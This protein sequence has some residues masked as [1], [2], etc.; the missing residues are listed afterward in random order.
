M[1]GVYNRMKRRILYKLDTIRWQFFGYNPVGCKILDIVD[2]L[3]NRFPEN[4]IIYKVW[5][6]CLP[7]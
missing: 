2:K 4:G 5:F 7:F 6:F 1:T 3:H